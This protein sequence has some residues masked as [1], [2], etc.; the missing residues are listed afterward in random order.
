MKFIKALVLTGISI[1]TLGA[2]QATTSLQ[3]TSSTTPDVVGYH[4]S[5]EMIHAFVKANRSQLV[6]EAAQG[7][8]AHLSTV[9]QVLGCSGQQQIDFTSKIQGNY[10]RIFTQASDMEVSEKLLSHRCL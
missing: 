8:G 6:E 7:E 5:E 2:C 4:S 1:L 3:F 9:A 10:A